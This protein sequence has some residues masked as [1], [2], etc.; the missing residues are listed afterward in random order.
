MRIGTTIDV[1]RRYMDNK[2]SSVYKN[3][4]TTKHIVRQEI[5]KRWGKE[6]AKKYNPRKNCFT[7][8]GWIERGYVVQKGEKAIRSWV[9]LTDKDDEDKKYP[10]N[11]FL[12]YKKQVKKLTKKEMDVILKSGRFVKVPKRGIIRKYKNN[13]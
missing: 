7:F 3:G 13:P 11:V 1:I 6:E 9:L 2:K 10:K 8:D 12:F 4:V 5:A